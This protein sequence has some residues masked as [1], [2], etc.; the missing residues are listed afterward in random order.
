VVFLTR[1]GRPLSPSSL[2]QVADLVEFTLPLSVLM[3]IPDVI[4]A[5]GMEVTGKLGLGLA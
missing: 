1:K 3:I 4:L 2:W 5:R